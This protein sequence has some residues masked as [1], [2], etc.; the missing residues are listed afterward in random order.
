MGTATVTERHAAQAEAMLGA[1]IEMTT[2]LHSE[3]GGAGGGD[4]GMSNVSSM[5]T[6]GSMV[7]A[8]EPLSGE[9]L[10]QATGPRKKDQQNMCADMKAVN[11][12]FAIVQ[13]WVNMC[14]K[15]NWNNAAPTQLNK[16]KGATERVHKLCFHA[17][18]LMFAGNYKVQMY[19]AK[20]RYICTPFWT[21]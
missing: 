15:E 13:I 17:M 14:P 11:A 2:V 6:L 21:S 5:S 10:L 4:S 18:E 3:T 20:Q 8:R 7:M 9:A 19:F 12:L 16:L 1:A